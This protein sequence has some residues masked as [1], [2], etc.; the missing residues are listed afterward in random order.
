M[1]EQKFG[2]VIARGSDADIA[3][4]KQALDECVNLPKPLQDCLTTDYAIE[5][6]SPAEFKAA[7]ALIPGTKFPAEGYVISKGLLWVNRRITSTKAARA[8]HIVRHELA[9]VLPLT[10]LKK[11]DLMGLMS[12]ED[13]SHPTDWRGGGYVNR[14]SECFADTF[15]EAASGKDSPWDD[16]AFFRLDV[17]EVDLPQFVAIALRVDPTP[18]IPD[19]I[20]DPLPPQSPE[21]KAAL[22]A[23]DKCKVELATA[24]ARLIAKDN[25]ATELLAI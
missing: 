25:K 4:I 17:K 20:P 23:L 7:E 10:G 9:H 21:L 12:K 13:G 18:P 2:H 15:A 22:E 1:T 14:P 6:H 19:P 3:L 16:F 8:R 24:Q 11:A 5:V